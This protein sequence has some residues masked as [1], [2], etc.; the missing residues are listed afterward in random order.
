[1][2]ILETKTAVTTT[3]EFTV[4][5]FYKKKEWKLSVT[6]VNKIFEPFSKLR[7]AQLEYFSFPLRTRKAHY[8]II[9][10]HLQ[11]KHK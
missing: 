2:N 6:S 10:A 7:T 8:N 5:V 3:R 4:T 1:M 9:V 11:S